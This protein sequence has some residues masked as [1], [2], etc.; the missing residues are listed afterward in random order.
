M[1]TWTEL[2]E[3]ANVD[4]T[5]IKVDAKAGFDWAVGEE[6]VIASTDFSHGHAE[7]R[8]I[9]TISV[10]S[11]IATIT[12]DEPLNVKHVAIIDEL[13]NNGANKV[14]MRAEVGL[15]TRN[16]IFEGDESSTIKSYGAHMMLHG[17]HTSARIR[18]AE[19]RRTGQ[20]KIIGR[21]PIHFHMVGDVTGSIV[22][23]NAVHDSFARVLTIHATHYLQ[24]KNNV[25]YNCA[26][27]N[28]FLEDGIET[29]NVIENNLIIG[30]R[31]VW[32]MLQSDITAAS[33]WITNPLNR[34]V[35]NRAA[36]GDFYGF[37]YE[38]KEHPDG[39]SARNDICPQG[40]ALG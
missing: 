4:A 26:G 13:F 5:E 23:G 15:L 17:A 40:M 24:V 2:S 27:H 33:Y 22:E 1:I 10:A 35:N 25:G 37:W 34:V 30:T 11:N 7:R 20:P 12:F 29:N 32:S 8:I 16:V 38:I 9:K 36:G 14:S 31:Q 39:P 6:I 19:F 3:T 21:Y 28:I 18:Y